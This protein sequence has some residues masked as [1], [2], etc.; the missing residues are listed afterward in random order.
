ML[1][2]LGWIYSGIVAI[3]DLVLWAVVTSINTVSDAVTAVVAAAF[4]VLPSMANAPK[5]GTP[6]W[7]H[8]LS[9][10]YPVGELIAGL[11]TVVAMW[12]VF[13]AGRYVLRVTR[14]I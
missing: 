10:F 7:L 1:S 13:L 5:I 11:V 2:I 14:A 6:T 8:W 3:G 9:W 12:V 4:A